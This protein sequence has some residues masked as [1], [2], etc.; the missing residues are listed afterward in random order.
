MDHAR[1][2]ARALVALAL[3]TL[4]AV[5]DA[6][7]P[8][9][10]YAAVDGSGD[11][12]TADA[13]CA[14]SDALDG[15]VTGSEVVVTPGTY[16]V[17]EE[18]E[19]SRAVAVHGAAG[20]PRPWL[21]GAELGG[22]SV[23]SDRHG[24]TLRHLGLKATG[25]GD[26]ALTLEDTTGEDLL[27]VSEQGKGAT[28]AG[29]PNE[30]VLRDSAVLAT[31]D[32]ATGL[33]LHTDSDPGDVRL[34]NVTAMAPDGEAVSCD[35]TGGTA[36]I[37]NTIARGEEADIDAS[38]AT[39]DACTASHS[40]FVKSNSSSEDDG[41]GNQESQPKFVDATSGD[42]R[43]LDGTP[44]DDKGTS[45]P[46]L[47]TADPAGCVRTLGA[48]PDI[49]AYEHPDPLA[50]ACAST[51]AEPLL[52]AP[53]LPDE[54]VAQP[55]GTTTP[56]TRAPAPVPAGDATEPEAHHAPAP[57]LGKQMVLSPPARGA[58]R[59]R[60]PGSRRFLTLTS[61]AHIPVGSVIDARAGHARL[62]S[63]LDRHG[64]VQAGTFWGA[65]FQIRQTKRGRGMVELY[66]RGGGLSACPATGAHA[67]ASIAAKRRKPARSLWG[68]DHHG[69]YR[70]HGQSSAATARGTHWVTRDTCAGTRTRVLAGAVSVRDH[71][72]H[73][74][75]LVRAGHSYLARAER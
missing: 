49:G 43:V 69:R 28:V 39:A 59:Y 7:T 14:L 6:T 33:K 37:V 53:A 42:Y 45:D 55:G 65:K 38:R 61:A 12:C 75:V 24:G 52:L 71:V 41:G 51:P 18:L 60:V 25:A 63:A 27:L 31:G 35:M 8:Q 4:P 46:E 17:G 66:L 72:R 3:L 58:I 11:A 26:T 21:V 36:A 73:R 1:V 40:N 16:R 47:G 9:A 48:R 74:T 22:D 68:R 67:S 30:T 64:R 54:L 10:R 34:V 50:D 5:A 62:T 13:P 57:V 70:T 44:T 32:D 19:L 56:V 29:S 20:Q 15:A 2:A 23:L